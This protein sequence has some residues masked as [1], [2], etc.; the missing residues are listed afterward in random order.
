MACCWTGRVLAATGRRATGHQF[1]FRCAA[2]HAHGYEQ[3]ET[4]AEFLAR[5]SAIRNRKVIRNYGEERFAH[6]IAKAIVAARAGGAIATTRQLAEIVASAVRTREQGQHPA[7]RSFQAIRI[8]VNQELEE[9]SLVLPQAVA[10]AQPGRPPRRHQLPLPRR[11]HRQALPARRGAPAAAA[12]AAAGARRRSAAA[13]LKL[14]GKAV[15]SLRRRNRRQ[16]AR[17]QRGAARGG[18]DLSQCS[19]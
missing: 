7:T 10:R 18:K 12:G 15:I 17:P 8:H 11:P 4:A 3:G 9:L 14:V 19:G 13:A 16:S 5:A 1:S 2:R 6:A